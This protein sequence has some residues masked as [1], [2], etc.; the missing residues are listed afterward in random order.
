MVMTFYS[1]EHYVQ[2]TSHV[3]ICDLALSTL[4][5]DMLCRHGIWLSNCD[6]C[7][8]ARAWLLGSHALRGYDAVHWRGVFSSVHTG[9]R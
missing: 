2:V 4:R 3:D 8:S 9:A 7:V 5:I 1:I 6:P